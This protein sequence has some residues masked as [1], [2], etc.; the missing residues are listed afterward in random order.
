MSA[1]TNSS[2]RLVMDSTSESP[3]WSVDILASSC[4]YMEVSAREISSMHTTVLLER[5][6]GAGEMQQSW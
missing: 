5:T 2:R 3:D 1:P 4:T 6:R